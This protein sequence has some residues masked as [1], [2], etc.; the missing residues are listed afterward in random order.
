MSI[1]VTPTNNYCRTPIAKT[2]SECDGMQTP[3]LNI[4]NKIEHNDAMIFDNST[5]VNPVQERQRNKF[6]KLMAFRSP[7]P[8]TVL[9]NTV[10][11]DVRQ[12]FKT[13]VV[14]P[15]S[16]KKNLSVTYGE[17][18]VCKTNTMQ[19]TSDSN[20]AQE[21]SANSSLE[22]PTNI[23]ITANVPITTKQAVDTFNKSFIKH[24]KKFQ[25]PKR[26]NCN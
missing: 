16:V 18:P 23:S 21:F 3:E 25:A 14:I 11:N 22:T 6:R 20:M 17:S 10:S 15:G 24:K 26:L 19:H 8:L 4:E 12:Q 13:P 7:P 9:H 5:P 2:T 1:S